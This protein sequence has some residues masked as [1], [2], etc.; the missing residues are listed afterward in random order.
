MPQSSKKRWLGTAPFRHLL[1]E[2]ILDDN[3]CSD[4]ITF[5]EKVVWKKSE[6]KFYTFQKILNDDDVEALSG[7]LRAN[8]EPS[9]RTE[10]EDALRVNLPV[11]ARFAAQKYLRGAGV[12]PHTDSG[13]SAARFVLNLNRRWTPNDGGIWLLAD[14]SQFLP[15]PE[16]VVPVNNSG[17]GFVPGRNTYHALSERNSSEAYAIVFEFP[18]S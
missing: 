12:G 3:L 5:L 11:P 15:E 7:L 14:N 10:L 16:F 18:I 8:A 13:V 17:F 6:E 4:L 1:L 9:I 2:N